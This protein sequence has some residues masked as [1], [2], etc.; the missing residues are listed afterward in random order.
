MGEVVNNLSPEEGALCKQP[1]GFV[2]AFVVGGT[3]FEARNP[4]LETISSDINPNDRNPLCCPP[5]RAREL[6]GF[7]LSLEN[8]SFG[9]VSNFD[10]PAKAQRYGRARA[11]CAGDLGHFH[12]HM[13]FKAWQA[14]I[15]ISDLNTRHSF[16]GYSHRDMTRPQGS[17]FLKEKLR[18]SLGWRV[19][20]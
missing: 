11:V 19:A 6:K 3:N 9:F 8:S 2:K 12:I 14:R 1:V 4:K 17:Y 13:L 7:F 18:E 20:P 15:R 16:Q 5:I 10:L